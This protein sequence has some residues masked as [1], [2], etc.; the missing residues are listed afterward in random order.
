[1]KIRSIGTKTLLATLPIFVVSMIVMTLISYYSS[2]N[3]INNEI[4]LKMNNQLKEQSTNIE[5]SLQRHAKI[6]ENL[7]KTVEAS[8]GMLTNDNY[9]ALLT[10]IINTNNE[11]LGAG[12]WFEPYKYNANIKFFGPYAYKDKGK[13]VYT[14]DYSADS[15]NYPQYDWYKIGVK[16]SNSIQWS[17]P[18]VDDVAKISMITATSPFYNKDKSFM[19][20]STAD[21]D[22]TT[23]QNMIKNAK[24]GQNGR[25]FLVDKNGIYIAD[26]NKDKIMKLKISE[27]SNTSIA[28][29]GK[30]MLSNKGGESSFKDNRGVNRVYYAAIPETGWTLALAI[31]ESELKAP[32]NNLLIK[33]LITIGISIIVSAAIVILFAKYLVRSINRVNNF[34]MAIAQGDLT[35]NINIKSN[36]EIGKMSQHLNTMSESMRDIV[37]AINDNSEEVRSTSE[38]LF[39]AVTDIT[40]KFQHINN[41]IKDINVGVQESSATTE[42]ISASIE[43][44]DSS[45]SQLSSKAMDG[46][47]LSNEIKVRA[48]KVK[49]KINESSKNVVSLFEEKQSKI[50]SAMEEGKIV[51]EIKNMA[52]SI[53][54]I[55]EQ[56]NLLALNAAIEAA[57]AGEQGKG[58]AVVADEVR[59]LAEQSSETVMGIHNTTSKVQYAFENLS[60]NAQEILDFIDGTVKPDYAETV[61]TGNQYGQDADFVNSMSEDIAAMSEEIAATINEI[62]LAIQNV[63]DTTQGS[64]NSSQE[65][66]KGVNEATNA[67][68]EV[69]HKVQRQAKLAH[70][71]H[72]MVQKFKIL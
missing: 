25:A 42:E 66:L 11:T 58:F 68:K 67:I 30:L 13:V 43:E 28:N 53:G 72:E 4:K 17:N 23:I 31:P 16:T 19:G 22:L 20:V 27:D 24:V 38:E 12:V 48:D 57:R 21:I 32:V 44:V 39:A 55:A 60:N 61:N 65:I 69:T 56:T 63:A 34:A 2:V 45:V 15:Y 9:V 33:L 26:E 54:E 52:S 70:S 36:D 14:D 1:M 62:N 8:A 71:L 29:L 5:R 37:K 49:N 7:S 40:N 35:Q 47:N 18:Y 64:A 41:S 46:S 6:A 59:K 51:N 10:K 3:I 50:L